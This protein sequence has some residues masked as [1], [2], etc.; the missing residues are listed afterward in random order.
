MRRTKACTVAAFATSLLLV[1]ALSAE[2]VDLGFEPRP[3]PLGTSGGNIKDSSRSFCCSGTLGSL[4]QDKDSVQY[5]LSNNHV[6]ARTNRAI[7]GET[8]IQPGLIDQIPGCSKDQADAVANL[9]DFV[10]ISFR[11][12]VS[13]VIDA[14]IAQV[15]AGQ[16]DPSGSI[17]NIGEISNATAAPFVGMN[18]KKN[19][20]TT[21]MTTGTVTAIDVTVRIQYDRQCGITSLPQVATF[22][23][24]IMIE[25]GAF[26][27]AGDSGSL[28]VENCSSHPRSVGLLFAGSGSN[29]IANPIGDVLSGLGVSMV[30]KN[31]FCS[32]SSAGSLQM[33][34][35]SASAAFLDVE[36]A[37]RVKRLHEADVFRKTG[38]VGIGVG[39][40]DTEP[41]RAVIEVYVG[42][43]AHVM[44]P[45]IPEM[46]EDVQVKIV[47]T[48]VFRAY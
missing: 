12:N 14:A 31:D 7:I 40:S 11:R 20:R 19:G 3:I 47:E 1:M 32:A 27:D 34:E 24:Q 38:V 8:I 37:I 39:R 15:Q 18:V 29:T 4:V 44:K 30:G 42:K 21:G 48:G 35:Q 28:I 9:S 41:G 17:L 2:S 43:P 13:N 25:P 46:M 26:S 22:T 6:L 36:N 5:I 45:F 10:P 33:A 16:V 23:G